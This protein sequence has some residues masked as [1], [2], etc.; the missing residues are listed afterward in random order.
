[1]SK[2]RLSAFLALLLVLIPLIVSCETAGPFSINGVYRWGMTGG[3]IRAVLGSAKVE[4]ENEKNLTWLE[5]DDASFL[6]EGLPCEIAFGL[7]SDRLVLIL[8]DFEDRVDAL[9]VKEKLTGRYGEGA[10]SGDPAV[11]S[12]LEAMSDP[13]VIALRDDEPQSFTLWTLTDGTCALM[14]VSETDGEAKAV[15]WTGKE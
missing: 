11:L 14:I 8:I 10:A 6:F 15:F 7:S 4:T 12:G 5:T 1:M 9:S 13:D 2:K 3:E